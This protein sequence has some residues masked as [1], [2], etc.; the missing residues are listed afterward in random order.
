MT[1]IKNFIGIDVSKRTLDIYIHAADGQTNEHYFVIEN[2]N[3]GFKELISKLRK[4]FVEIEQCIVCMEHTGVYSIP[5]CLF[6]EKI[7][8]RYTLESGLQIKKSMGITR[9]K[10]DKIDAKMIAHYAYMNRDKL[11]THKLPEKKLLTLKQMSSYR[12]RL[13]K[14][15][16]SFQVAQKEAEDFIEKQI[17]KEVLVDSKKVIKDLSKRIDDI[18][19]KTASL[20]QQDEQLQNI[21]QLLLSIPGVGPQIAVNMIIVTRSFT[22]F[23]TARQLACY[24]G[25]APFEYRSGTS[26]KGRNKVSHFANK[27]MKSLLSMGALNAIRHDPEIKRYYKRKLDEGKNAM[28]VINAIRNKLVGRMFATVA[29]GT[30]F[31]PLAKY[32]A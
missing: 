20:I 16:K 25:I 4:A 22:C 11:C 21:Y 19:R 32:A 12:E 5:M 29:R 28:S 8:L 27:K 3:K 10:S 15:R 31:V 2:S 14:A 30:P 24:A 1:K 9:G 7:G 23:K 18:D 26:I 13:V 17:V 6:L